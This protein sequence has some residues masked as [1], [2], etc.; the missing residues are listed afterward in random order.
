M[1]VATSTEQSSDAVRCQFLLS[2]NGTDGEKTENG[3][4]ISGERIGP[5]IAEKNRKSASLIQ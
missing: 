3:K 5:K 2:T 4:R 1:E